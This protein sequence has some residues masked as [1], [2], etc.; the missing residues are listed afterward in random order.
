MVDIAREE[1]YWRKENNRNKILVKLKNISMISFFYPAALQ[2][3]NEN[4]YIVIKTVEEAIEDSQ[5]LQQLILWS[6]TKTK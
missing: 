5:V 6:Y 1:W 4:S 2:E 3:I